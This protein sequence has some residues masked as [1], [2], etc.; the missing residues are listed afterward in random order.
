MVEREPVRD[1]AAAVVADHREAVVAER[2]HQRDQVGGHRPLAVLRVV[3]S[4]VAA[5]A[6]LVESP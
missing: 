5:G 6:G 1:P 2:A 4:G 3:S